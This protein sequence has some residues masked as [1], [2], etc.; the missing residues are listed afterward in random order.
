MGR[1]QRNRDQEIPIFQKNNIRNIIFFR[2]RITTC[3]QHRRNT[4]KFIYFYTMLSSPCGILNLARS[5]LCFGNINYESKYL[6]RIYSSKSLVNKSICL[7]N[8]NEMEQGITKTFSYYENILFMECFT[9]LL[10]SVTKN[11]AH[12]LSLEVKLIILSLIPISSSLTRFPRS[13]VNPLTDQ[14]C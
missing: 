9:H 6:N 12:S 2:L 5:C 1:L 14:I 10:L 4:E 3:S 8:I 11:L 7:V 13:P